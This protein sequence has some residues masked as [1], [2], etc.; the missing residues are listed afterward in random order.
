MDIHR[1]GNELLHFKILLIRMKNFSILPYAFFKLITP[2][3]N[4][5]ST[6]TAQT[7][8]QYGYTMLEMPTN[9]NY[10]NRVQKTYFEY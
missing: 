10:S 5:V 4:Y 7:Y 9:L 3:I 6:C 8:V 2:A 1:G